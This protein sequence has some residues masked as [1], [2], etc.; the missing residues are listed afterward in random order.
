MTG[1]IMIKNMI[2]EMI[3][4]IMKILPRSLSGYTLRVLLEESYFC[5]KSGFTELIIT[6][7]VLRSHKENGFSPAAIIDC[8]AYIGEWT[9]MIKNIYPSSKVLMI[10]ANPEKEINLQAVQGEYPQT[11]DYAVSLLGAENRT[12]VKFYKME[13]G[14]SILEEQSSAPRDI[15][16]LPMKTLDEIA[17]EKGFSDAAFIKIDVQ[18][19]EIEVLKGAT[20]ILKRAELVLLEVSFIQYN[21]GSPLIGDVV[22][23]MSDHGFA[24]YDIGD[25]ARWGTDSTLVQGDL[26]FIKQDSTRRPKYFDFKLSVPNKT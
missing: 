14:S 22:N 8:G 6:E 17:D 18:G 15:L 2:K 5:R 1:D 9:R 25:L 24:V 10:E 20:K 23:F 7:G 11:V 26:F 12:N 4:W 19:Y 16:L 21:K 3:K 13:S